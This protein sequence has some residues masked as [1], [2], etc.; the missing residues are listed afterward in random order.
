LTG[1][2]KKEQGFTGGGGENGAKTQEA[3]HCAAQKGEQKGKVTKDYLRGKKN[4]KRDGK[5]T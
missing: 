4:Q 3:G 1:R 5:D 2:V